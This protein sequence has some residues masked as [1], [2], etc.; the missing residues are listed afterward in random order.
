MKRLDTYAGNFI[1]DVCAKAIALS[2]E[3]G[4]SVGFEFNQ[5]EIV[6]QPGSTQGDLL[7]Q[8]EDG[9]AANAEAYRVKR[10]AYEA[11]PEGIAE[12]ARARAEHA[13]KETKRAEAFANS[14]AA[15]SWRDEAG[16]KAGLEKNQDSYGGRCYSYA[17]DWAR[18]MQGMMRR[19][20]TV[21]DC[22]DEASHYADT[23]GITGFMYGAAVSILAHCW[24]HGEELRL[25]HNLKTQIGTEGERANESGGVLNPA[26]LSIG[27]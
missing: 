14:D 17:A 5:V 23:D 18:I 27:G 13:T 19:G 26:L 3:T 20:A 12:M 8:F 9:L 6:C 21:S 4:E 22:A 16:Y 15:P 10:A 1:N 11:S 25:W 2:A 7:K 24:E